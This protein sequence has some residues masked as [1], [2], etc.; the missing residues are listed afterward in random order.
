MQVMAWSENL[1]LDK[2]KELDV[3]PSNKEDLMFSEVS[4]S[5]KPYNIG[6][7]RHTPEIEKVIESISGKEIKINFTPLSK[8]ISLL[9]KKIYTTS[10]NF[11]P[12][13]KVRMAAYSMSVISP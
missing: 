1:S 11:T 3:L 4:E 5:M 10:K 9:L 13:W 12:S 8:K 2:C 6:K 7:H